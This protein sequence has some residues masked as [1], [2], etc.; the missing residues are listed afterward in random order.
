M[1]HKIQPIIK[2]SKLKKIRIEK[3]L[4]QK[5]LSNASGIPVKCIGNYEQQRRDLNHAHAIIVYRL[6]IALGCSIY[7][8]LDV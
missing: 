2:I 4:S 1:A 7:D 8:L 6:S 5:Q 3:N